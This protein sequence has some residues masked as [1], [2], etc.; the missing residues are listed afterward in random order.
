MG[1][2]IVFINE[3]KQTK[4]SAKA[5]ALIIIL[6]IVLIIVSMGTMTLYGGKYSP[7]KVST[8]EAAE[9]IR[10]AQKNGDEVYFS[11]EECNEL[12]NIYFSKYF[13][14]GT[15]AVKAM[16]I[17]IKGDTLIIKAPVSIKGINTLLST[18]GTLTYTKSNSSTTDLSNSS[19]A[20]NSGSLN[21]IPENFKAGLLYIPKNLVMK[22]LSKYIKDI[23]VKDGNIAITADKMPFQISSASVKDGKLYMNVKKYESKGLFDDKL[24]A[25]NKAKDG[26]MIMESQTSSETEKKKIQSAIEEIN[27][28]V[29]QP[30][31]I[32][33][34]VIEKVD[35]KLKEIAKDNE[36]TENKKQAEDIGQ[37]LQNTQEEK[38]KA[39]L[40]RVG[41]QL[42][43][44]MAA[45][46]TSEQKQIIASMQSTIYKMVQN[47]S[48]NYQGDASMVK[49]MY[50]KLPNN[51]KN[52]VKSAILYNVDASTMM[53]LKEAFGM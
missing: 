39:S 44:A 5:T 8:V 14:K 33:T 16:E 3:K 7:I 40:Q 4:T 42:S 2:R 50:K 6:A 38:K 9:K 24:T 31:K 36:N 27:K 52:E 49:N 51:L 21:Y 11:Q 41:S 48:Y 13:N 34:N 45:V 29:K 19:N 15:I 43:G 12:I 23:T 22:E 1:V 32:D 10:V 37:K 53:E 18:K 20:V 25:L 47:P 46:K 17:S 26:L 30:E 35:D 28:A